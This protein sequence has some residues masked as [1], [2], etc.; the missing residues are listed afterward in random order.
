MILV[1]T[2][3]TILAAASRRPSH[4]TGFTIAG[5][6]RIKSVHDY[7][8]SLDETGKVLSLATPYELVKMIM[9]DDI[10]DLQLALVQ[11]S[12]PDDIKSIVVDPY[13]ATETDQAR[14][15]VRVM[16][17]SH[18]SATGRA[19]QGY[20]HAFDRGNGFSKKIRFVSRACW[21]STTICCKACTNPRS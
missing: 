15:S 9:G 7:V 17:T 18:K 21:C 12:L 10:D 19:A 20:S 5:L 3:V 16:E 4:H 13:L 1:T 8:D 6:E 2:S 11:K 14:I